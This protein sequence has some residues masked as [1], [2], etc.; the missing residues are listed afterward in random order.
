MGA[1]EGQHHHQRI[2]ELQQE[3]TVVPMSFC[4]LFASEASLERTLGE[5]QEEVLALFSELA[6]HHEWSVKVYSRREQLRA[7]HAGAR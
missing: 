6:G 2:V 1:G 5:K 3:F 7:V 4:T